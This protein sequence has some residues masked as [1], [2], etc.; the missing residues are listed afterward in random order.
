MREVR[1]A[2]ARERTARAARG[3]VGAGSLLTGPRWSSSAPARAVALQGGL[4]SPHEESEEPRGEAR[5]ALE[6][7]PRRDLCARNGRVMRTG[8]LSRGAP[9][10]THTAACI[11]LSG[12][13]PGPGSPV[14]IPWGP[15]LSP[16]PESSSW[17][18][19]PA[20][21]HPSLLR[22]GLTAE[23]PFQGGP[24]ATGRGGPGPGGNRPPA[25]LTPWR[26]REAEPPRAPAVLRRQSELRPGTPWSHGRICHLAGSSKKPEPIFRPKRQEPGTRGKSTLAGGKPR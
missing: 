21:S 26:W 3:G 8:S 6:L 5:P 16:S 12:P 19:G 20:K 7:R 18:S 15:A 2:G 25:S 11:F 22:H 17:T 1:K 14:R 9:C 4:G 24:E 10:V 23:V 13:V